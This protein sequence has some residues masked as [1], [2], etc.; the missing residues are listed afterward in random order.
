MRALFLQAAR[1]RFTSPRASLAAIRSFCI[2]WLGAVDPILS[3]PTYRPCCIHYLFVPIHC[4]ELAAFT[5]FSCRSIASTLLH[6]LS[7]RADPLHR[8]CCI[9]YLY[10]VDPLHRPSCIHFQELV[11]PSYLSRCIHFV[12]PAERS[13]C[14]GDLPRTNK[15]IDRASYTI[16]PHRTIVSVC[17]RILSIL[18]E[19]EYQLSS[20]H[21]LSSSS[22]C[23]S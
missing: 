14:I 17:L 5:I 7:F 4:I 10:R 2:Q 20:M 12:E 1:H 22:Q 9:H 16:C 15:C 11:M 13:N 8:P 19:P 21:Y 6:S 18:V 23:I 3:E